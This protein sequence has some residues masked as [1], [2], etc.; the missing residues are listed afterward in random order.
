MS[1][2]FWTIAPTRDR[3]ENC[4]RYTEMSKQWYS[5]ELGH[6]VCNRCAEPVES[7]SLADTIGYDAELNPMDNYADYF[8]DIQN[9][10]LETYY[11]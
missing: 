2:N 6:G 1:N 3:C 8:E 9:G 5:D 10:G 11:D 4:G 7:V